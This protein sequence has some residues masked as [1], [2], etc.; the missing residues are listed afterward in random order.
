MEREHNHMRRSPSVL[1]PHENQC[2]IAWPAHRIGESASVVQHLS[3][4]MMIRFGFHSF[5]SPLR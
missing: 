5:F 3:F 4:S 2:T 1:S